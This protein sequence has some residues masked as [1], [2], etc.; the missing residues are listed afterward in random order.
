MLAVLIVTSPQPVSD[1]RLIDELWGERPPA[2]ARHAVQVHVSSLRRAGVDIRHMPATGYALHVDAD[3]IDARRFERLFAAAARA[4][5][6]ESSRRLLDEALALWRADAYADVQGGELVPQEAARLDALRLDAIEALLDARLASGEHAQLVSMLRVFVAEHPLRERAR[7]QLMIALY[8]SGRHAE[9]LAAYREGFAAFDELGLM[10]SPALRDLEKAILAHDETLGRDPRARH[11]LPLSATPLIG[12]DDDV[13]AVAALLQAA[14]GCSRS[15]GRR[16]RQDAACARRGRAPRRRVR[17]RAPRH[18][19]GGARPRA[20]RGHRRRRAWSATRRAS[21]RCRHAHR[22]ARRARDAAP[23][24]QLR[25]RAERR[26]R[27][28][29]DPCPRRADDGVGDKPRPA[30]PVG[31][32]RLLTAPVAHARSGRRPGRP[33]RGP[34]QRALRAAGARRGAGVRGRRATRAHCRAHL[35]PARRDPAR[36]R[37]RRGPR[38]RAARAAVAQRASTT[39]SSSS[40][41]APSTCRTASGRCGRRS[42]GATSC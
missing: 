20:R 18:A 36:D 35:R 6:A 23:A 25:A 10:P 40:R 15:P 11:N 38:A 27:R 2:S 21:V 12:R 13:S 14:C 32:G 4:E 19:R 9:A 16:D 33:A 8:R 1:A 7:R 24:R 34:G 31:G 37:A 39:G 29:R 22:G 26:A 17:G 28:E 42:I 41:V 5:S 3:A 30:A